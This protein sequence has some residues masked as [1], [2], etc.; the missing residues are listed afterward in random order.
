MLPVP[1]CASVCVSSSY[2]GYM[3]VQQLVGWLIDL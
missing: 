1:G 2:A 3:L